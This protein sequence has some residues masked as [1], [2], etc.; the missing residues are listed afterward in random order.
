[1]PPHTP[2]IQTRPTICDAM[3]CSPPGSSVQS[4]NPWVGKIPWRRERL[5]IPVFWPSE[6]C[7]LHSPRDHK[8]LDTTEWFSLHSHNRTI[9]GA[10]KNYHARVLLSRLIKSGSKNALGFVHKWFSH[11]TKVYYSYLGISLL[12]CVL[13][14]KEVTLDKSHT[15]SVTVVQLFKSDTDR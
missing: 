5:P 8:E 12:N 3:D 1:M 10:I 11:A 2:S 6:F 7:E 15:T 4:F 14:S 9:W 13:H